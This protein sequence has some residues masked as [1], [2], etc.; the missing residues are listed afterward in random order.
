MDRRRL[1]LAWQRY[2]S[3]YPREEAI[4]HL[5]EAIELLVGRMK[6]LGRFPQ[7]NYKGYPK[8]RLEAAFGMSLGVH[9]QLLWGLTFSPVGGKLRVVGGIR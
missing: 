6:E 2:Y 1:Y 9:K 5:G 4:K 7:S 3:R 8:R